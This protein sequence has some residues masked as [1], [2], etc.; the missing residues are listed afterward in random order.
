MRAEGPLHS[1]P[2]NGPIREFSRGSHN[3]PTEAWQ[4]S[5]FRHYASS[6]VGVVEIE[7]QWTPRMRERAGI[8]LTL[9]LRASTE[10]PRLKPALSVVEGVG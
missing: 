6:E 9:K 7:S 10:K 1:R 3:S 5:G 2:P 4:W 8:F